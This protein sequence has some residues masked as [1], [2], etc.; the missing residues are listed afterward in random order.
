VRAW[1]FARALWQSARGG[2]P[3]PGYCTYL[4][5]YRCN[6]RCRMCDSWRLKPGDELSP[7]AAAAIFADLGPLDVVRLT[8]GEPFL[9]ADLLELATRIHAASRPGIL[10]ITTNGSFPDRVDAFARGFPAP[11]RLSFMVSID[12]L[13]PRHD[14]N[15]GADVLFDTALETVERLVALRRQLGLSVSVNHTVISAASLADSA[16]L[17]A[18]LRPLGVDVQSVLAYSDSAMYSIKLRGG[19]AEHLVA[20]RGY[21]LHPDLAGADVIGFVEEELKQGAALRS[22][23]LRLGKRYY[24]RGLLARLRGER[25]PRPRPDCVALRSHLRLLPDGRVPV[26]QFNTEVVGDLRDQS[27]DS[28]WGGQAAVASRAWVDACSGCWAECEVIPSAVYTGDLLGIPRL[29]GRRRTTP[30][31]PPQRR[32]RGRRWLPPVGSG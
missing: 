28:V 12:G 9:R 6:A 19:R 8:G 27:L 10:H 31:N 18:R 1:A 7:A 20:G 26:C 2:V 13:G 11:R 21:P 29:L 25:D 17:K 4:V 14:D 5:T 15:R 23:T 16:A 30:V 32:P 22:P 24:L 3:R